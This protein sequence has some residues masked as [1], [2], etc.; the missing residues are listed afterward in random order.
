MARWI[1]RYGTSCCEQGQRNWTPALHQDWTGCPVSAGAGSSCGI[2]TLEK[3]QNERF[4]DLSYLAKSTALETSICTERE[5]R[6]VA[7]WSSS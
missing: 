2:P 7:I 4:P 1:L 3:V 5:A 6:L